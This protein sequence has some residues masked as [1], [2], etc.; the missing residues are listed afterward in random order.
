MVLC[1]RIM[2]HS[3]PPCLAAV[4][5]SL[6]Q[7]R[8]DGWASSSDATTGPCAQIMHLSCAVLTTQNPPIGSLFSFGWL[9]SV[10]GESVHTICILFTNKN[11]YHFLGRRGS[12][13]QWT[14]QQPTCP[15]KYRRTWYN[16]WHW[17]S[18][19]RAV[20]CFLP[21]LWYLQGY[22]WP[23]HLS[24][25]CDATLSEISKPKNLFA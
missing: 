16:Y 13:Q 25:R 17:L 24:R 8:I 2:W 11:L 15:G 6:Q 7:C 18:S 22:L 9:A 23:S 1:F 4:D 14:F 12:R 3:D 19:G 5:S 10:T 21:K 20:S